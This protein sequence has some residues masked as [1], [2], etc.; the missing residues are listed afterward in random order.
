M[1]NWK[2]FAKI[3]GQLLIIGIMIYFLEWYGV[4]GVLIF[5]VGMGVYRLIKNREVFMTNLKMLEAMIWG[6]PLD[7]EDWQKGEMKNHKVKI[8]WRKD[9]NG[10]EN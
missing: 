8:I 2:K 9:K 1:I 6:K 4:A 3:V 10:K 5:F 7:K